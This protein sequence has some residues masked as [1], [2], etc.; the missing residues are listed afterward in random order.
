MLGTKTILF[1]ACQ[2]SYSCS[3]IE[4]SNPRPKYV[5]TTKYQ[6]IVQFQ[7]QSSLM[8]QYTRWVG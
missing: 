5:N 7:V 6:Q 4:S 8:I 1:T 3:E 2:H